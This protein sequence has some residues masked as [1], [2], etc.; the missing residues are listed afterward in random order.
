MLP[1]AAVAVVLWL[2]FGQPAPPEVPFARVRRETLA[3]TIQTNGNVE[4]LHR[5]AVHTEREGSVAEVHVEKGQAI[6]KGALIAVLATDGARAE[7]AAAEA[8]IVQAMADLEV[9]ESGGRASELVAIDNSLA[10]AR[11]EQEVAEQELATLTRL[12][13]RQ[14][15]TGQELIKG[16]ERVRKAK[17]QIA[18]LENRR[19]AVVSPADQR[20]GEARLRTAEADADRANRRI[21][22]SAIRALIAGTVYDLRVRPGAYLQ[23]GDLVAEVGQLDQVRVVIYVDEPELGRVEEGMPVVITWDALPGREWQGAVEKA[24][25]QVV[26]FGARRVG[27][28]I[29]IIENPGLELPPGANINAEIRSRVSANALTIPRESLRRE[30]DDVGVYVLDGGAAVWRSVVL[31]T[32]NVTRAEVV[33]GLTDTDAVALPSDVPLRD[34]APVTPVFP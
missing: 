9:Y 7:L 5:A 32:S 16:R 20:A 17:L 14:A 18:S 30:G 34:G 26:K 11:V 33:Q 8:R 13:G 2:Y 24:P 21:E 4:P 19:A 10:G 6:S 1:G 22:Q 28:V 27:E 31:G 3:S 23:P 25:S 15:V 29:G 12:A